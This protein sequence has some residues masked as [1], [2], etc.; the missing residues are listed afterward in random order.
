MLPNIGPLEMLV[1]AIIA[2]LVIG[3]RRLPGAARGLGTSLREFRDAV[4]GS[5]DPAALPASTRRP[6]AGP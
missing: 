6:A 3:P 4:T 2:L 5:D 1:V